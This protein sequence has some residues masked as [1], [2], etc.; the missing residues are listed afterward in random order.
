MLL[1]D[2]DY[3][4]LGHIQRGSK[5]DVYYARV[6]ATKRFDP[7]FDLL[8]WRDDVLRATLHDLAETP[9][10]AAHDKRAAL[11]C[12]LTAA[13]ALSGEAEYIGD[14]SGGRICLPPKSLW[15]AWARDA[16]P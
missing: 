3:M 9:T 13:C 15:A 7:I 12:L 6:A 14:D 1:D 2:D 11:V 16:L 10:R 8:G 4:A 5:S